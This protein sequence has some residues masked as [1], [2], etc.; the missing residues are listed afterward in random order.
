MFD[1]RPSVRRIARNTMGFALLFLGMAM[2]LAPAHSAPTELEVIEH[3]PGDGAEI[4][5]GWFVTIR[6]T[7]WIYDE[8][9]ADRKGAQFIKSDDKGRPVTFVYGYKRA[10]PGME[11]GMEGMKVGARRTLIIPPKLGFASSRQNPPEGI[12]RDAALVVELELLDVVPQS[13]V[14]RLNE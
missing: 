2:P 13:N 7:G 6:Y 5:R 14:N 8:Q 12:P 11:K 10:L 4:R 1:L 3:T 9:A